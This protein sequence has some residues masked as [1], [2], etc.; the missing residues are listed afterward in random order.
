MLN[1]TSVISVNP[2]L[3]IKMMKI[4]VIMVMMMMMKTMIIFILQVRTLSK[5]CHSL[6]VA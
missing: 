1:V 2:T 4:I 5:Q 3:L 6:H